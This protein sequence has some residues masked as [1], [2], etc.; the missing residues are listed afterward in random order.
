MLKTTAK[1]L[2]VAFL[3]WLAVF[4][5]FSIAAHAFGI[6]D[7]LTWEIII[8]VVS[9]VVSS[10]IA[11]VIVGK[12]TAMNIF[13][14]VMPLISAIS[15]LMYL[16][17]LLLGATV[18]VMACV[19]G[20]D[21]VYEHLYRTIVTP[22]VALTFFSLVPLAI[23]FMLFRKTRSLGGVS[24]YLL[25]IFM[26]FFL[27]LYSL[28]IL[29]THSVFWLIVGLFFAGIGVIPV[30]IISSAI[31]GD[32]TDA[33]ILLLVGVLVIGARMFGG[34]VAMK[35]GEKDE[36]AERASQPAQPV[37]TTLIE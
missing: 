20:W 13:L 4:E 34:Y 2:V 23:V 37:E 19:K 22:T 31:A 12:H 16:V 21:W 1:F 33:G 6:P 18:V 7:T 36:E 27:W 32:W 26:G 28:L 15:N 30:A 10:I 8:Q 9:G 17:C 14:K 5:G 35:Q 29:G 25:S 3:T 24:L 11:G